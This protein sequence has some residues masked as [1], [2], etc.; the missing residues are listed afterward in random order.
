MKLVQDTVLVLVIAAAT[1]LAL[2][3]ALGPRAADAGDE[4]VTL[5]PGPQ[6]FVENEGVRFDLALAKDKYAVGDK[7][8]VVITMT[9]TSAKEGAKVEARVR[10]MTT[11]RPSMA[12]RMVPM[13]KESWTSPITA[14][15]KAGETRTIRLTATE[16]L[17]AATHVAFELS[18]GKARTTA[19]TL[20]V[21]A[22]ALVLPSA[23]LGNLKLKISGT[24][25]TDAAPDAKVESK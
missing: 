8:I 18:S 25:L 10:M 9:N 14:D 3:P 15:L 20:T 16:A 2:G 12:A 13:P 11:P 5:L 22:P 6:S 17:A 24:A 21:A 4:V 7:P 1:T 19:A 23:D